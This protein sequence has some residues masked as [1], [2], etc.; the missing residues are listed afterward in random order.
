MSDCGDTMLDAMCSGIDADSP[1]FLAL[2]DET[3][4]A[5][6]FGVRRVWDEL[7]ISAERSSVSAQ[8]DKLMQAIVAIN[9]SDGL[10]E[11]ELRAQGSV[12]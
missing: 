8:K 7:R 3:L 11:K 10:I 1:R 2:V 4:V 5:G 12:E 6:G 9:G